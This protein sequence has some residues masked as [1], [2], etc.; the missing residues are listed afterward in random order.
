MNL[1]RPELVWRLAEKEQE[2]RRLRVELETVR[3]ENDRLLGRAVRR[4]PKVELAD[5]Q[6]PG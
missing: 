5:S 3:R 6:Y 2:I 1:T 4:Q